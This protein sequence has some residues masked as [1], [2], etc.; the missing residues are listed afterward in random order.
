MKRFLQKTR[1]GKTGF[2]LI[3]LLVVIAILGVLAAVAVPNIVSF[4]G[5]GNVG[6]A[7]AELGMVNT[8]IQADMAAN[9]ISTFAAQGTLSSGGDLTPALTS[10]VQG[11]I[12]ALKGTYTVETDGHI[13]AATY[14]NVTD[15]SGSPLAFH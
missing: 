9:G 4:I 14:P 11:G 5:K 15:A 8:A 7:N 13:S 6:A 3:E 12:A 2:T 1:K 10:Y